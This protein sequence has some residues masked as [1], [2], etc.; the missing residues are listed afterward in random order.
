VQRSFPGLR[1]VFLFHDTHKHTVDEMADILDVLV[2]GG[3]ERFVTVSEYMAEAPREEERRLSTR[4]P[5]AGRGEIPPPL[6]ARHLPGSEVD[7]V[8]SQPPEGVQDRLMLDIR[9][10]TQAAHPVQSQQSVSMRTQAAHDDSGRSPALATPE[11]LMMGIVIN[12]QTLS[13][14]PRA[15][16]GNPAPFALMRAGSPATLPPRAAAAVQ[17]KIPQLISDPGIFLPAHKPGRSKRDVKLDA[18]NPG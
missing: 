10:R 16:S 9:M 5:N 8:L 7:G 1:G 12:G 18:N 14:P 11:A 13:A 6:F 15:W 3:C 4:V 2:A 17:G